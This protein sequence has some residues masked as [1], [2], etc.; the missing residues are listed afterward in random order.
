MERAVNTQ[1]RARARSARCKAEFIVFSFSWSCFSFLLT[2]GAFKLNRR[3]ELLMVDGEEV[4]VERDFQV[5]LKF[6]QVEGRRPLKSRK[7]PL[8]WCGVLASC[9]GFV[10][11]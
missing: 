11:L 8:R 4:R 5:G 1:E 2:R 10:T 6:F 7:T 3:S 9:T